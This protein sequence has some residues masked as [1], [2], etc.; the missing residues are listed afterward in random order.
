MQIELVGCTCA[1]KT[2]LANKMIEAGQ[3]FG[4][5]VQLSDDFLL[6]CMR[7]NWL[8]QE[9]VRRRVIELWALLTCL[10]FLNKYHKLYKL[11]IRICFSAPGSVLY[12]VKLARVALKKIGIYEI[13]RRRSS[14]QQVILLDNEGVLQAS[15]TLFVHAGSAMYT[16]N[17]ANF[18]NL[19][20]LPDVIAYLR[21][22]EPL[23]IERTLR[24]GHNRIPEASK[25]EEVE[26]F[27]SQAVH[28]F[29]EM[30]NYQRLN[31]RL[32]V[33]D[34]EQKRILSG[35]HSFDPR[36]VKIAKLIL[37]AMSKTPTDNRVHADEGSE[38]Q[39]LK[40]ILQAKAGNERG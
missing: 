11:I 30:T 28:I 18:F 34:G 20:P 35:E 13:I 16:N 37:A 14:D 38:H 2:T 17:L 29:E 15:H 7:L 31:E 1:G 27:I 9:F 5:D 4:I 12:H 36:V 8:K 39:T 26:N 24:R 32:I 6:N 21:L 33:I 22:S 25:A 10:I 3:K 23:L 19:A 40:V